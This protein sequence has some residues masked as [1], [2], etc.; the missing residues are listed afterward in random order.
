[1]ST[2]ILH[3]T[4]K[5]FASL[6]FVEQGMSG[7]MSSSPGNTPVTAS[8]WGDSTDA[9]VKKF[10]QY[11]IAQAMSPETTWKHVL[12]TAVGGILFIALISYVVAQI[13]PLLIVGA[14]CVVVYFLFK[15][16]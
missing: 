8:P 9:V 12:W 13:M 10:V 4:E 15:R 5:R 11:V 6:D 2:D 1:M 7:T 16:Q 3:E 14:V